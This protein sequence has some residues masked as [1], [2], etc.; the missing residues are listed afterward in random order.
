MAW[1]KRRRGEDGRR[2]GSGRF[3]SAGQEGQGGLGGQGGRGAKPKREVK[4]SDVEAK[5]MH[6]LAQRDHSEDELRQKLAQRDYPQAL[7]DQAIERMKEYRYLDDERAAR[8]M[9][10]MLIGQ[11]WGPYQVKAKL[12]AKGFDEGEIAQALQ[13]LVEEDTWLQAARER[14]ASKFREEQGQGRM[15]D[16]TRGRAYRHLQHR[17]FDGDTVRRALSDFERAQEP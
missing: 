8:S 2:A 7:I 12:K 10:R 13:E 4:L 17:G 5:A 6:L 11:R 15:D 16:A 3:G 9:A 1:M 14:L